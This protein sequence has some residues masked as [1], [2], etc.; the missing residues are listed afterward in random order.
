MPTTKQVLRLQSDQTLEDGQLADQVRLKDLTAT[1]SLIFTWSEPTADRD[2]EF[3]DPGAN[4]AV[5]YEDL[6]QPLN[7]KSLGTPVITDFSSAQ[8][9]HSNAAGGGTVAHADIGSPTAGDDHT[10]YA[11]L[12]GRAGGQTVIGGSA[13]GEDL[14]LQSTSHVTRGNIVAIDDIEMGSGKEITGLPAVPSGAT[15]AASKAY[16]DA[17]VLGG[18]SWKEVLLT[19]DQL[20]SV[21][22]GIANAIAFYYVNTA[23][24]GDVIN[25]DD[26][27]APPET[28]TYVPG[29]SAPFSPSIGATPLDS[30]LDLVVRINID[31]ITWSATMANALQGINPAGNVVLIYR[32]VPS[33]VTTDQLTGL[34]S[35]PPDAWV[36]DYGTTSDY[37]S[38][39]SSPVLPPAPIPPNFGFGRITSALTPNEAHLCRLEDDAYTW[40]QD[41]GQWQ[42]SAGGVTLATSGSGGGVIGQATY[43]SDKGLAVAA[44]V[45]EVKVDV[46]TITFDGGGNLTV[47][48]GAVPVATSGSGGGIEG[49]LTADEDKGLLITGG[50]ANAIAEVK[51]DATSIAFNLSGELS[52]TGAPLAPTGN[53]SVGMLLTRNIPAVTPPTPAFISGDIPVQEY[54]DA[55]TTGQLFDFVVP[56]DYDSGSIEILASYQMTTAVPATQIVLEMGAKIVKASTGAVDTTTFPLAA[57]A[58][59]V[60]GTTNLT[61]DVLRSFPNPGGAN[62]QRGDTLQIYVK[63]LGANGSDTHT[64]SWR[65][66]A[67]AHRYTGQINTRLMEPVVDLFDPVS[68]VPSPPTSLYSSD[69]PVIVYSDTVNQAAAARFV[70][71]DNWDGTSDAYLQLQYALDSAASG[72]VRINTAGSILDVSGGS[73]VAISSTDFDRAVTA[74]T[75]PH[76]TEIVRSISG[77]SLSAGSVVQV[78]I[79]RD[80]GV[81]GNAAAG[82]QVINATL[83]FGVA[84]VSGVSTITE[85]YLQDPVYG[86]L[87]GTVFADSV[88]PVFSGDFEQFYKM[89]STAAAGVVHVAFA[90]RLATTQSTID[91]VSVFVEGV[92]TGTVQ[93]EIKIYA[94][95]S[96]AT[97]VYSS[98]AATPPASATQ[99]AVQGSSLSAQPTG[100]KKFFVVVE[101]TAMENGESVSISKPFVSLA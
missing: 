20:D 66:A 53:V 13:S 51:V 67:F 95:G 27:V 46:S 26:G 37:Q 76:R 98:G 33:A 48:G 62:Y 65:V 25:L 34:F 64:G 80:T 5:V 52:A 22:D 84:P 18:A 4:D 71:P 89:R 90:G 99:V 63:R 91:E 28:Y 9:D 45:A 21:N 2:I 79:T 97:P 68:G 55:I 96:G 41:A 59:S 78:E 56:A 43:D 12:A 60:P 88:Y 61:R 100:N 11:L 44:G 36:V 15:A 69:I 86:N 54:P 39:V 101:A 7:N 70:V 8:H 57:A 47:A 82:F 83:A 50:P 35:V 16:V 87:S 14:S 31:S 49:K 17:A 6:A 74:D 81:G 3:K 58:L 42:L 29:P 10:Q 75:N 72:T 73:V 93:Y 30:M 85:L 23:S 38:S 77:S 40:N 19:S 32:K 1:N 94:E 24:P 92:D